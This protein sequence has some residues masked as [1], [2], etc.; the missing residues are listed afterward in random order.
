MCDKK[1]IFQLPFTMKS[2]F[3]SCN[4]FYELHKNVLNFA[5]NVTQNTVLNLLFLSCSIVCVVQYVH[6]WA[7][8]FVHK[9]HIISQKC[10]PWWNKQVKWVKRK[11]FHAQV[12]LSL[13]LMILNLLHFFWFNCFIPP[14]ELCRCN[15]FSF[16]FFC[17]FLATQ[18]FV[19]NCS[20]E[21]T[22]I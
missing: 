11:N 2:D 3:F 9:G 5:G 6:W 12:H 8:N 15:L 18:K 21:I 14:P 17:S 19:Y 10:M 4:N 20:M 22:Y 16:F 13:T 1:Q 7:F